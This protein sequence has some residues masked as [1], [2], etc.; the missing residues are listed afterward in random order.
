MIEDLA[1]LLPAPRISLAQDLRWQ[2]RR[3][4][5]ALRQALRSIPA[6]NGGLSLFGVFFR[7][8]VVQKSVN[9]QALLYFEKT[10]RG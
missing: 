9:A 5:G 6:A 3:P 1:S 2:P 8:S 7:A 4:Q 10:L